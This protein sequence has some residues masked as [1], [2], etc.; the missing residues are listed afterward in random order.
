MQLDTRYL[1]YA[2]SDFTD[3]AAVLERMVKQ[4]AKPE[5]VIPMDDDF[6]EF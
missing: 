1:S 2:D 3:V 5:D 6:N 4:I